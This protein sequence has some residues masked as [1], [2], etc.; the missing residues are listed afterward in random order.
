MN[1]AT[2]SS[3]PWVTD[4]TQRVRFG[5]ETTPLPDW[6][7]TRDFVQA[8]EGLG[9]DSLWVPDHPVVTGNATWS[10]LGA[11]AQ[12]TQTIR[13]GTL[14]SCVYYWNPVVLARSAVDV[15]RISG[16]RFVLGL[17]SG[18]MPHEFAH[19]GLAHP[20]VQERQAALEDG[21]RIVRP[22]LRGEAVTYEGE[23]FRADGVAFEPPP[24]QQP[25]VPILVA[26]G[27]ERTTLRF[28][29][30]YADASNL[31]AASWAGNAFTPEDATRKFDVLR[32][33]CEEAG[34][35]YDAVLRTGLLGAFLSESPEAL[36]AKM[37]YVPPQILGFFE[38]LPIVGTPE[39]AVPR[40]RALLEAGF[41]YVIFI[42]LPFDTE[43][44]H[45][46]AERVIP[47]VVAG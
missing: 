21:L 35:S 9:F 6:S 39:D 40:V 44:L 5:V 30:Q 8:A 23:H 4:G 7:A 20:P 46:L 24:T 22:L 47:A 29:A 12:A 14:V 32:R 26:G 41:Q 43:S 31:G 45:L 16:G 25:Y 38:Q 10:W 2:L 36:R 17:G 28:V 11:I 1:A 13:L 15:D 33:H 42:V 37:D 18:D 19:M 34:R 3:H 27:G